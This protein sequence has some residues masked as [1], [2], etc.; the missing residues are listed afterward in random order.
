MVD[1]VKLSR[2]LL[3]VGGIL[4]LFTFSLILLILISE[5]TI[6]LLIFL[7]V[8]L[9]VVIIPIITAL[10]MKKKSK[11][12]KPLLFASIVA[13]LIP[14]VFVMYAMFANGGY[15]TSIVDVALVSIFIVP[16]LFT[17]IGGFFGLRA[18]MEGYWKRVESEEAVN[19]NFDKRTR[20]IRKAKK[21][22]IIGSLLLFLISFIKI[23]AMYYSF[24][25][26]FSSIFNSE[27]SFSSYYFLIPNV[28]DFYVNLAGFGI[29]TVIIFT[30]LIITSL[31]IKPENQEKSVKWSKF[32][33]VFAILFTIIEIS[34]PQMIFDNVSFAYSII[35]PEI[36]LN[37]IG[38]AFANYISGAGGL[39]PF[40]FLPAISLVVWGISILGGLLAALGAVY[41]L[42][43]SNRSYATKILIAAVV[44]TI[45]LSIVSI[46]FVNYSN[47]VALTQLNEKINES[48]YGFRYLLS[49]YTL[50]N[51]TIGESAGPG[52][53]NTGFYDIL[54]A[55]SSPNKNIS[56]LFSAIGGNGASLNQSDLNLTDWGA[57][58]PFVRAA[59]IGALFS[60]GIPVDLYSQFYIGEG[61][62]T[63]FLNGSV[64]ENHITY[65]V[66]PHASTLQSLYELASFGKQIQLT[67]VDLGNLFS[68]AVFNGPSS[69]AST[70]DYYGIS[71]PT[72]SIAYSS[73]TLTSESRLTE[74]SFF[75]SVGQLPIGWLQLI[76]EVNGLQGSLEKGYFQCSEENVS[77][78]IREN[79]TRLSIRQFFYMLSLPQ[80]GAY[81]ASQ[82]LYNKSF[83]PSIE[84]IGYSGNY[85]IV[86]L[87]NLNLGDS[88]PIYMYVDGEKLN[89]TRYFNYLLSDNAQFG[90]GFHN[91]TISSDNASML[92]DPF[93]VSPFIQ[94]SVIKHENEFSIY[95]ANS[96][97]TSISIHDPRIIVNPR[98]LPSAFQDVAYSFT[99]LSNFTLT[100]AYNITYI[101][102][103]TGAV[104]NTISMPIP[105]DALNNFTLNTN[106]TIELVYTSAQSC[107][108][109]E[110]NTGYLLM[111]TSLGEDFQVLLGECK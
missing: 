61:I 83:G 76:L 35:A 41:G 10:K 98:Y 2:R 94:T 33:F 48:G 74:A 50:Y 44:L 86:N 36:S 25:V 4:S 28:S 6:N 52:L 107:P 3:I 7:F 66:S 72:A 47:N 106:K 23:V 46:Y 20:E 17:V 15:P 68:C 67:A 108:L 65:I 26:A 5:F 59:D 100:N 101:I 84:F 56:T 31:K 1:K 49:N 42:G 88:R 60:L 75:G 37:N 109:G 70:S 19:L 89:Y 92:S 71:S 79:T 29:A 64:S 110:S 81:E 73:G 24:V 69:S 104:N 30:L 40:A 21:L 80:Y 27:V 77:S 12:V 34:L 43:T 54:L 78:H 57:Y 102:N 51:S 32:A 111:N 103:S 22:I 99:A 91:L 38:F 39:Q 13:G 8:L 63:V 95:L 9:L 45:A 82:V 55:L 87:G 14:I 62:P 93:Y 16:G 96:A 105:L 85:L 58:N 90:V 53:T 97:N 18:D 11:L